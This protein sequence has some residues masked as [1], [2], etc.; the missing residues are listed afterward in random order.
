MSFKKWLEC[1]LIF[2]V[3]INT[4]DP[5]IR[6]IR[7]GKWEIK[8]KNNIYNFV[9]EPINLLDGTKGFKI[10]WGLL[11]DDGSLSVDI[12]GSTRNMVGLFGKIGS[13]MALFIYDEHPEGFVMYTNTDKR[14]ARI[15]D[16]MWGK[17]HKS[18]PFKDYFFRDRKKY[19]LMNGE[20]MYAFHYYK[21]VN[22]NMNEN[23]WMEVIDM[24]DGLFEVAKG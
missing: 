8:F 22:D 1:E 14:L 3:T 16:T 24:M 4:N 23:Q 10:D 7:R 19:K 21:N 17:F 18:E 15:Y 12:V 9:V 11:K 6:K 13:C 5:D 20:D 2:E